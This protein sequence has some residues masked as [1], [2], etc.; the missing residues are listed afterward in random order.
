VRAPFV[1]ELDELAEKHLSRV[2][3]EHRTRLK[4]A[5]PRVIVA[6]SDVHEHGKMALE[7]VLRGLGAEII[8]GGVST[9]PDVLA[10]RA[11]ADGAE[12]VLVSTY[13]GIALDYYNQ[14]KAALPK[15]VPVLIG[16]RLNQVPKGSNTS[17]PVDVSAELVQAG[18]VVCREIEDAV[19]ALIAI[20]G[21]R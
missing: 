4:A 13:N 20:A 21:G 10:A 19:P 7:T 6:T 8:D 16:G 2:G 5:R 14:L 12:A 17:L 1:E 18:A 15:G 3:A 11:V 9:D